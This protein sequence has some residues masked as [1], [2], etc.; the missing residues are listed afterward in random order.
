MFGLGRFEWIRTSAEFHAATLVCHHLGS[1][2]E[3]VLI[4]VNFL[5]RVAELGIRRIF[6][7]LE[8]VF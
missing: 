4:F 7:S 5:I 3:F 1:K 6:W 2:F 8:N